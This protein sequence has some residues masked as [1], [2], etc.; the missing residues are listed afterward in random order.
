[1]PAPRND[2]AEDEG[3]SLQVGDRCEALLHGKWFDATVTRCG[4]R[5]EVNIELVDGTQ[6]E[7]LDA[8]R[9]RSS[10]RER[11][12]ER[13]SDWECVEAMAV[14]SWERRGGVGRRPSLVAATSRDEKRRLEQLVHREDLERYRDAFR[15]A[16][17]V[18]AGELDIDDTLAALSYLNRVAS[19]AD[20]LDYA[21][22]RRALDFVEF[23]K[24]LARLFHEPDVAPVPVLANPEKE[25][26][27]A[28][29]AWARALGRERL[30]AIEDVFQKH[31]APFT[32]DRGESRLGLEVRDV[33]TVLRELDHD[34]T[35]S[36]LAAILRE[37]GLE[38]D[39]V[40]N[41]VEFAK[42]F[43]ALD[44]AAEL[45]RRH[46]PDDGE[47]R[48]LAEIAAAVF[49]Q[50]RW[51]GTATQH[52]SLVRRL[53][54]GRPPNVQDLVRRAKDEFERQDIPRTGALSSGG[55]EVVL[56]KI[57]LAGNV[58]KET[59][60]TLFRR[61]RRRRR[62]R[63]P[64]ASTTD[65][66][67]EED[68]DE[69]QEVSLAEWFAIAGPLLEAS[70]ETASTVPSAFAR[71][72]L[73]CAP[74]E[75]RVA[76]ELV[77]QY[78][79]NVLAQPGEKQRWRVPAENA[80]YMSK[81]GR[82]DGGLQL[83]K[84]VGFSQRVLLEN[85]RGSGNKREW[86]VLRGAFDNEKPID[87]LPPTFLAKLQSKL[88]DV[89]RE[90]AS[91]LGAPGVATAL[92]K[93]RAKGATPK[94]LREAVALA[95]R[96]ATNVL[97]HPTDPK[98]YRVRVANQLVQTKILGLSCG[99]DLA[100]AIGFAPDADGTTLE[101]CSR[102]AKLKHHKSNRDF[103]FPKLDPET[104]AFL[105]RAVSDLEEA[106]LRLDAE[107]TKQYPKC[108]DEQ[109]AKKKTINK[110]ASRKGE[111]EQ[112]LARGTRVQQAQLGMAQ[113]AFAA[114]DKDGDGVVSKD[115]LRLVFQTLGRRSTDV[116]LD[117]W[118]GRH[119][120]DKDGCVSFADF[121]ASLAPMF[122]MTQRTCAPTATSA[123]SVALDV[124]SAIA[125]AIGTLRLGAALIE[126]RETVST[127]LGRV[128]H[129]VEA[130]ANSQLWRVRVAEPEF[131]RRVADYA[132][133]IQLMLACGFA[134][135]ENATVV[136]LRAPRGD[137]WDRVPAGV[138][139]QLRR[140]RDELRGRLVSLEHPEV[141]DVSAIASAA[142]RL[143]AASGRKLLPAVDLCAKY[144]KNV[145]SNPS[146]DRLRRVSSDNPIFRERVL[147]A[148]GG[149]ELFVATGW[150]EVQ[151]GGAF[152][153]PDDVDSDQIQ[154]RLL[155]LEACSHHLRKHKNDKQ[156]PSRVF[157]RSKKR[158]MEV[159][160]DVKSQLVEA[161]PGGTNVLR[162][163]RK[164]E[165]DGW[166]IGFKA[167][168]G[169]ARGTEERFVAGIGEH[170]LLLNKPL[171][172]NHA[173]GETAVM[174][175]PSS[176]ERKLFHSAQLIMFIHLQVLV[177]AIEMAAKQGQAIIEAREA[178]REFEARPVPRPV[179]LA[180]QVFSRSG[181]K[182]VSVVPRLGLL[183]LRET[184]DRE[185]LV[186][187][188]E[189]FTLS[190]LRRLFDRINVSGSGHIALHELSAAVAD[191][192]DVAVLFAERDLA[193]IVDDM[194]FLDD[195]VPRFLS[196]AR[197]E[198]VAVHPPQL[199]LSDA[200]EIAVVFRHGCMSDGKLPASSLPYT[201]AELEGVPPDLEEHL[202][203]AEAVTTNRSLSFEE[204]IALRELYVRRLG[205]PLGH[206]GTY[207]G[208]GINGWRRHALAAMRPV[209]ATTVAA[210]SKATGEYLDAAPGYDL[211]HALCSSDAVGAF[212][213]L[214]L[215]PN[216]S[217]R[218]ELHNTIVS[219]NAE[220]EAESYLTWRQVEALV[221][222]E[223]STSIAVKPNE[224][225]RA[226]P[227]VLV[228]NLHGVISCE[229][230]TAPTASSAIHVATK[231]LA[232]NKTK[233][234][235]VQESVVDSVRSRVF[236][237]SNDG[238]LEVWDALCERLCDPT[239]L[240]LITPAPPSAT[241]SVA[242]ELSVDLVVH[243]LALKP[244]CQSLLLDNHSRLLVVNTTAGDG[245]S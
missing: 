121:L 228:E 13:W 42:I 184:T 134:L 30:V 60:K 58:V 41:F 76:G 107:I 181:A 242:P 183:L 138:L 222:S 53:C 202:P 91:Y 110:K 163:L 175:R 40:I 187:F 209:W 115:D 20:V 104:E 213:M 233:I 217:L 71:L 108:L 78:L 7:D 178:Q 88:H 73:K 87:R 36:R 113:R 170:A 191:D 24:C 103:S 203:L 230:D 117:K 220:A 89:E 219:A 3:S 124:A 123:D 241:E 158:D 22:R 172:F 226:G 37:S 47:L 221:Y 157:T 167:R 234:R 160:H 154:A 173:A 185:R 148:K 140:A 133:G 146:N 210:A 27:G 75:V 112:L 150:R 51:D 169:S 196:I 240:R 29:S 188:A 34:L 25:T 55:A 81:V 143:D 119:D 189:G 206:D 177:P 114:Y 137:R 39:D 59:A 128:Q 131:K 162:I 144:L 105:Y 118:I 85:A 151:G 77:A 5:G 102:S 50:A 149:L 111:L 46:Q 66:K 38:P 215:R 176:D 200:A 116:A 11:R 192:P 224:I 174:V 194:C 182:L 14:D 52:A 83:M 96:C 126:V 101:L 229:E 84:A 168:V 97:K 155:E 243:M 236:V 94:A 48:P 65:A 211:Y 153:L 57:G 238:V 79:T 54:V 17:S 80:A 136:A 186:S 237:L 2:D 61:R 106:M 6:V 245:C 171:T 142:G 35:P 218:D 56:S 43:R 93:M 10:H 33:R 152:F 235:N 145:M 12:R 69:S 227:K 147:T 197:E 28:V 201:F 63:H 214:Q 86:L 135:E 9:V 231:S 212:L 120:F 99:M 216:V 26:S 100:R 109:S 62:R 239:P 127:V 179:Y 225:F 19:R 95:H 159:L 166:R 32:G 204:L 199:S 161:A 205:V 72:R 207:R 156:I 139:A 23:C 8:S 4:I 141:A 45:P 244:R 44:S 130:P 165:N 68:D 125:A 15:R 190:D 90:L 67:E 82:L 70:A 232:Q 98:V 132:G 31:C 198:D 18:G 180:H 208:A 223:T 193:T 1:M 64:N 195:F 92:R 129:I 122:Q 74:A 16:D 49:A 164:E 21:R